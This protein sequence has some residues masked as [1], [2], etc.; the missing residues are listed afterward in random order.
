MPRLLLTEWGPEMN[1]DPNKVIDAIA[2]L[3]Q[4]ADVLLGLCDTCHGDGRICVGTSG[5]ESDG[6]S[7]L[8]ETCPECSGEP[9]QLNE[10]TVA[11]QLL[12]AKCIESAAALQASVQIA[13]LTHRT[14]HATGSV[15]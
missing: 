10:P 7:P 3:K 12:A 15:Q 1:I 5:L 13:G 4:A 8:L 14:F 2:A 11:D 9:L 6:D